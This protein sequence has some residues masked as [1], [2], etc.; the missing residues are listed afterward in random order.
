MLRNWYEKRNLFNNLPPKH[1]IDIERGSWEWVQGHSAIIKN[2]DLKFVKR[3]KRKTNFNF[4]PSIY[5]FPP[6]LPFVCHSLCIRLTKKK[7]TIHFSF[8]L[9]NKNRRQKKFVKKKASRKSHKRKNFFFAL[10]KWSR[11]REREQEKGFNR[12]YTYKKKIRSIKIF[13]VVI[14]RESVTMRGSIKKVFL[15]FYAFKLKKCELDEIVS[16]SWKFKTNLFKNFVKF[17]KYPQTT[18]QF[19]NR[20]CYRRITKLTRERWAKLSKFSVDYAV[21]LINWIINTHINAMK[22]SAQ[23]N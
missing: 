2:F 6:S 12:L 9:L 22:I 16:A 11:L 5:A 3:F 14:I 13:F 1:R 7:S 4:Q 8:F 19:S 20:L 21:N 17:R 23:Q 18:Q 15:N 10:C